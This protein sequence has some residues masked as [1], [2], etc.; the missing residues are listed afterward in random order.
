M[1]QIFMD[2][3]PGDPAPSAGDWL[4]T[5]YKRCEPS[6]YQIVAARKVRRRDTT[7]PP[8]YT[9]T[10]ERDT[11]GAP[12]E[13]VRVWFLQWYPRKRVRQTQLLRKDGLR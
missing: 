6:T 11:L 8:R 1:S 9:L 5:V 7:A 3:Q 13:G 2:L 12:P 10:V 4:Q